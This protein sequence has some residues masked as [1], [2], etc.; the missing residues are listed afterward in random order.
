MLK[1]N[2][3]LIGLWPLNIFNTYRAVYGFPVVFPGTLFLGYFSLN[4]SFATNFAP[5]TQEKMN[6]RLLH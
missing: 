1:A 4:E 2:L 5:E 3:I 6:R